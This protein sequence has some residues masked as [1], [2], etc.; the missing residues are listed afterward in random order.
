MKLLLDASTLTP[1]LLDYGERLLDIAA[2]VQLHVIDLTIY[3]VGNS[4]W[5]LT[6]LSKTISLEDAVEVMEALDVLVKRGLIKAVS[7]NKLDPYRIIKLAVTEELSFYDSSYIVA[8]G[9]LNA[10]LATED[11]ELRRKAK[12]YVDVAN[13]EQLCGAGGLVHGPSKP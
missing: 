4:L 12:K 9:K 5:K 2:K 6:F 13:Y 11:R 1:L 7:F 10:T 3:E 8:A